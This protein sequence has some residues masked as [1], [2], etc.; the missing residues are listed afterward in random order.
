[1][2]T[3]FS[4]SPAD[5]KAGHN[6]YRP[7]IDGLRAIAVILV[8]IYHAAPSRLP[9][10]FIG[11][12]VFFVISGYLITGIIATEIARDEFSVGN[13]YVRR[14]RRILPALSL[15]LFC[16]GVMG[17]LLLFPAEFKNL[18]SHILAAAGFLSNFLLLNEAGYFDINARGKPLLHL[19]SLAVEEQFYLVWPLLLML[20]IRIRRPLAIISVLT[21]LSLGLS[22]ALGYTNPEVDFYMLPPRLW[23]L[24]AGAILA[25]TEWTGNG[26]SK[27]R[28]SSM[29]IDAV[30]ISALCVL[31]L[32]ALFLN[33]KLPYPSAWAGIP[34]V[35]TALLIRYLPFAS[36]SRS[37]MAVKPLVLLGLISYPLYLWHWPLLVG[38]SYVSAG[39]TEQ[40]RKTGTV[41]V[42]AISFL[43]AWLT[44]A[45]LE[46]PVQKYYKAHFSGKTAAPLAIAGAVL[47]AFACI[48]Q[49]VTLNQG[50]PD[51]FDARSVT[52]LAD[53]DLFKERWLSYEK[54][55]FPCGDAI[56]MDG[57]GLRCYKLRQDERV[58]LV[59]FGDSHA[60]NFFV[61]VAQA[62]P[63]ISLNAAYVGRH[64]CP[65]ILDVDIMDRN[66]RSTGCLNVTK[67]ALRLISGNPNIRVVVLAARGS[68]YV[69][70]EAF[71]KSSDFRRDLRAARPDE[72]GL[73]PADLYRNGLL[74]TI[75]GLHSSGKQV[76][77]AND[78][79]EL[80]FLPA[81]CVERPYS[82][83]HGTSCIVSRMDVDERQRQY[84]MVIE[85]I[86]RERDGIDVFNPISLFCDERYCH[87]LDGGHLLYSD[88]DHLSLRG[89]EKL[90]ENF[91]AWLG[92]SNIRVLAHD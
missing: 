42:V 16:T 25:L 90:G 6:S 37:V 80:N 91:K 20:S 43:F 76:I 44:W 10:G 89:A 53:L 83:V 8:V 19:W 68:M 7:E 50:F 69:N 74:R 61:G 40:F 51:R 34:V 17:A 57:D 66:G 47:I 67:N 64:G 1:M 14:A 31:G 13:F 38:M 21:V 49:I 71:D 26:R 85:R 32:A 73:S 30:C 45:F 86:A 24:S 35:T 92:R 22:V 5:A 59:I 12:D 28:Q 77:I 56:P 88:G 63:R 55:F 15:V 46:K 65:A 23:E 52:A 81:N 79:P 2:K 39:A 62:F 29:I 60:D 36:L 75:D 70:G 84:L 4:W 58:S 54:D 87:V 41:V 18:G 78:V 11:V 33:S 48:G 3:I 9:G 27:F 82:F 72:V